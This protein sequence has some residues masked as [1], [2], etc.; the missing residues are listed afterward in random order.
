MSQSTTSVALFATNTPRGRTDTPRPTPE[1]NPSRSLAPPMGLLPTERCAANA[2][3]IARSDEAHAQ[4]GLGARLGA[5]DRIWLQS[6]LAVSCITANRVT[7]PMDVRVKPVYPSQK[8][9]AE[10]PTR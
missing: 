7:M 3:H 6:T 10:N 1:R 9:A 8:C 4:R 2:R 5:L